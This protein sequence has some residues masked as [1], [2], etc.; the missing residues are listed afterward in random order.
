M[1]ALRE[2]GVTTV[3][4]THRPSLIAHVDKVM[5]LGAG[6]I[7]QFGPAAEVMKEMQRQA[8]ASMAKAA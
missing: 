8:Q 2:A 6:R 5:V 7:Q 4:I 1:G 3:V